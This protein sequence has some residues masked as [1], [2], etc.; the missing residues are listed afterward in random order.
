[1]ETQ[2]NVVRDQNNYEQIKLIR[3]SLSIN[4]FRYEVV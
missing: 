3:Q 2:E 4:S 1:M